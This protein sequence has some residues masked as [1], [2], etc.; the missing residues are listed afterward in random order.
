MDF[1]R[2]VLLVG[3]VLALSGVALGAFGAHALAALLSENNRVA[4]F[5]L[6]NRYQFY[7]ALAL[8]LLGVIAMLQSRAWVTIPVVF[9][10]AAGVIVFSGSLYALALTNIRWLGA[11]TPV[12][13]VLLIAGWAILSIN[14]WR[15]SVANPD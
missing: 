12:G 8:L 5:E 4:T 9:C 6:A 10:L 15:K 7:H 2:T 11:V 1:S 13:G 3:A 14:L